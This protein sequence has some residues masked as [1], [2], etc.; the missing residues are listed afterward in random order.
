M[1]LQYCILSLIALA[2]A[3]GEFLVI[4]FLVIFCIFVIF[5]Q[6]INRE[7]K[8]NF[9]SKFSMLIICF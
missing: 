9:Q 5:Y 6:F 4:D 3:S 7:M 1:K 8:E 2:A